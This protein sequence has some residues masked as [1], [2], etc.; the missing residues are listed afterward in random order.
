[1][2]TVLLQN[3]SQAFADEASEASFSEGLSWDSIHTVEFDRR[4]SGL[5]LQLTSS[6]IFRIADKNASSSFD[7]STSLSWQCSRM[8]PSESIADLVIAIGQM[9]EEAEGR[10]R[11]PIQQVYSRQVVS[12]VQGVLPGYSVRTGSASEACAIRMYSDQVDAEQ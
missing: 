2:V 10:L 11:G 7:L 3:A 9:I 8:P 5:E 4:S 1:M 12:V 6:A